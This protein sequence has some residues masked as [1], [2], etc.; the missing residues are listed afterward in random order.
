MA[1]L[2]YTVSFK[3]IQSIFFK[4]A[5]FNFLGWQPRPVTAIFDGL[6][7]PPTPQ[8]GTYIVFIKMTLKDVL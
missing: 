2:I 8:G 1:F 4:M 7:Y 6:P 3:T 5:T